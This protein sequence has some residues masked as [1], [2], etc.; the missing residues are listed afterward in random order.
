M[1]TKTINSAGRTLQYRIAGETKTPKYL[2]YLL[3]GW[4]TGGSKSW[5]EVIEL[6]AKN[7]DLCVIAP[8]MPGFA[9][10]STEPDGVWTAEDFATDM[11]Q[12]MVKIIKK[13]K[14]EIGNGKIV[15]LGHSF[16][17]AV[18]SL[19]ALEDSSVDRLVLLAAAVVRKPKSIKV[20]LKTVIGKI[21]KPLKNL[22]VVGKVLYKLAGA[23]DYKNSKPIMK[24]IMSEVVKTDLLNKVKN[25]KTKTMIIWGSQDTATPLEHGKEIHRAIE[26]SS[27]VVLD[28]VN[29]GL[30][31][32]AADKVSKLIKEFIK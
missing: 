12:W 8:D 31:L 24:E 14:I 3:H 16:G 5:T 4:N 18:A 21:L 32:H 29:H 30:Q 10:V 2:L 25:V 20:K 27:L 11:K 22:P 26:G 15:L 6:L 13:E 23:T 7:K 19:I 9:D 17:G 1:E 28:G